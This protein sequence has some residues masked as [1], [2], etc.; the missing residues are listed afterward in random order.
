MAHVY[1][2]TKEISRLQFRLAGATIR[3]GTRDTPEGFWG[4]KFRWKLPVSAAYPEAF[5]SASRSLVIS[6]V[7]SDGEEE[8][9]GGRGRRMHIVFSH[10]RR[11]QPGRKLSRENIDREI[12]KLGF[13]VSRDQFPA[14]VSTLLPPRNYR[15]NELCIK[16]V[17][18]LAAGGKIKRAVYSL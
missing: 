3:D 10:K 17:R 14:A 11:R 18:F 13:K 15:D 1:R 5:S 4:E 16:T 9:E 7:R 8:E 6:P 12:S 2:K